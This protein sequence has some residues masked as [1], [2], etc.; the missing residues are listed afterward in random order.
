MTAKQTVQNLLDVNLNVKKIERKECREKNFNKI[1][2]DEDREG[3]TAERVEH[4]ERSFC[5][6]SSDRMKNKQ[7]KVQWDWR[8]RKKL[9]LKMEEV[10][11]IEELEGKR[12]KEKKEK[13]QNEGEREIVNVCVINV[14]LSKIAKMELNVENKNLNLEKENLNLKKEN[15]N[16]K[17]EEE[18]LRQKFTRYEELPPSYRPEL[19][20]TTS[21]TPAEKMPTFMTRMHMEHLIFQR[22]YLEEMM[23]EVPGMRTFNRKGRMVVN[24][25]DMEYWEG[26][27]TEYYAAPELSEGTEE[28]KARYE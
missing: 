28:D 10:R 27:N 2:L 21:D 9:N 18:Y 15:F 22:A 19:L 17:G 4:R 11:K 12:R 20:T 5:E 16:L 26:K 23:M 3:E 6:I 25:R 1:L 24:Q 7:K 8:K 13:A 14:N